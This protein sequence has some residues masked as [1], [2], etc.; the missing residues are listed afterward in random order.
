MTKKMA[1][2]QQPQNDFLS[3]YCCSGI[4]QRSTKHK[5]P[6][7]QTL[8]WQYRAVG[9]FFISREMEAHQNWLKDGGANFREEHINGSKQTEVKFHLQQEINPSEIIRSFIEY[10]ELR[11]FN[12][13]RWVLTDW[14]QTHAK[15]FKSKRYCCIR[16]LV[17]SL[18]PSQF[19]S[20]I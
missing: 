12:W 16:P 18:S 9:R 2:R 11:H 20:S 14:L 3:N 8:S 10:F 5:N 19:L 13:S 6:H 1:K 4:N 17:G 7:R 15:L